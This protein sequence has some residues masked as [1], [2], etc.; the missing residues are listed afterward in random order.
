[1]I[2]RGLL[3]HLLMLKTTSDSPFQRYNQA[4]AQNQPGLC[5]DF[6]HEKDTCDSWPRTMPKYGLV[7]LKNKKRNKMPWLP[8]P[9]LPRLPAAWIRLLR[10]AA[11]HRRQ[12]GLHRPRGPH[13]T[14]GLQGERCLYSDI[15][16][17]H[18]SHKVFPMV[19]K[20]SLRARI[21]AKPTKSQRV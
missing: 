17:P 16:L 5:P 18:R 8:S 2:D 1:M 19:L 11:H 13:V 21:S 15:S 20:S 4:P 3:H 9:L 14:Q 12:H 7:R 6:S 10:G